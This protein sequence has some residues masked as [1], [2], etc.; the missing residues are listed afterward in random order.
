[1]AR[2]RQADVI[3]EETMP[4]VSNEFAQ[5]GLAGP[6]SDPLHFARATVVPR[7]RDAPE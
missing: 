4:M 3:V 1:M 5:A 2:E 7:P 6:L